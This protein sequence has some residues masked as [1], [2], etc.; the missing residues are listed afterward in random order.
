MLVDI[1]QVVAALY[2]VPGLESPR[3][4]FVFVKI[5][6]DG[7]IT[8]YG[9]QK[10]VPDP[11][12]PKTQFAPTTVKRIFDDLEK[13]GF[14]HIVRTKK[15]GRKE[16]FYGVTVH[17]VIQAAYYSPFPI[18]FSNAWRRAVEST[19]IPEFED[20]K[21]DM[22]KADA[23]GKEHGKAFSDYSLNVCMMS[24]FGL[25]P[26]ITKGL[27]ATA[28]FNIAD[29]IKKARKSD[30]ARLYAVLTHL[31]RLKNAIETLRSMAKEMEAWQRD[32]H[33]A[34]KK[35]GKKKAKPPGSAT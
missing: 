11:S 14:I 5:F 35:V 20:L 16:K 10:S 1:E 34:L 12:E 31:G 29:R 19:T 7:P 28:T 15:I 21:Q 4:R 25:F 8:K 26:V 13:N 30:R 2:K 3:K 22:Q 27:G 17:G 32:G 18:D 6:L 9:V 23:L 33:E 24:M